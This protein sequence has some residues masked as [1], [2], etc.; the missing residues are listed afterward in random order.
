[1]AC[2]I[3]RF[4]FGAHNAVKYVDEEMK[5]RE[6]IVPQATGRCFFVLSM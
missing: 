3:H 5:K 2:A 6:V 1:V 4:L